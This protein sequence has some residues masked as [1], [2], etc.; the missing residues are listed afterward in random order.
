MTEPS[1]KDIFISKDISEGI[2]TMVGVL[3]LVKRDIL[4]TRRDRIARIV[5]LQMCFYFIFEIMK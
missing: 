4:G 3:M 1:K 2:N 5:N